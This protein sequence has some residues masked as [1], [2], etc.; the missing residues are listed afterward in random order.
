MSKERCNQVNAVLCFFQVVTDNLLGRKNHSVFGDCCQT[1]RAAAGD[2]WKQ[3]SNS[4]HEVKGRLYLRNP[5]RNA[6]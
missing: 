1:C 6:K 2:D 3:S 5:F 4:G